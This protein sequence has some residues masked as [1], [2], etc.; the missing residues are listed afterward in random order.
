MEMAN[1]DLICK[2]VES[3]DYRTLK[4]PVMEG[5][6]DL[7]KAIVGYV[8]TFPSGVKYKTSKN[9]VEYLELQELV[10][11]YHK[12]NNPPTIKHFIEN[13]LTELKNRL[14]DLDKWREDDITHWIDYFTKLKSKNLDDIG[15]HD[16]NPRRFDS[17][18]QIVDHSWTT[19][20]KVYFG[21]IV[22]NLSILGVFNHVPQGV[23]Y[24]ILNPK[25]KFSRTRTK[26][27]KHKQN[28]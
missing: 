27:P 22:R 10:F 21:N 19:P 5:M 4:I 7:E 13:N 1:S 23:K 6:G 12:L 28:I 8:I 26:T 18:M 16:F 17:R 14:G 25:L 3:R 24:V 9:G 2:Y 11:E 20:F 15:Y